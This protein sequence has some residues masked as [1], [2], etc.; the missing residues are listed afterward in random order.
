MIKRKDMKVEELEQRVDDL[1]QYTGIGDL[2]LSGFKTSHHSYAQIK[3]GDKEGEDAPTGEL[4]TLGRQVVNFFSS[5]D[6]PIDSLNIAAC[7]TIPQE[8]IICLKGPTSYDL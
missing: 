3:A 1:E 6:I 8:E 7:H 5:K 2:V 4:H